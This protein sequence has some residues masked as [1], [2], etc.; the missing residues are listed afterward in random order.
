MKKLGLLLVL[1]IWLVSVVACARPPVLEKIP[2]LTDME[3]KLGIM[4]TERGVKYL[5]D[6]D[7]LVGGGPP[8]DGIPSIDNPL[9]VSLEEA[10]Q[11]IE[12]DELVLAISFKGVERVYP[13]QILVWHEI[14]NDTIAGDLLL[15]TF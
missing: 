9:F 13:L 11:W 15:I 1:S 10:D 3:G 5:V 7:K 6:P 2:E 12:E 14:V 8:K 4:V